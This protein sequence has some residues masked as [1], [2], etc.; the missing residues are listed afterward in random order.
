MTLTD[1]HFRV[2][3]EL[4]C[5]TTCTHLNDLLRSIG[6]TEVSWISSAVMPAIKRIEHRYGWTTRR[7]VH[8]RW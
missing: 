3:R 2:R 8:R 7:S 6:D 1:L 5:I 4:T